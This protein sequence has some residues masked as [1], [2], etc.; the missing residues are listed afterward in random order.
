MTHIKDLL[1]ILIG[2]AVEKTL[3]ETA[4]PG[5]EDM[6]L[7]LKKQHGEDSPVPFKIAWAKYSANKKKKKGSTRNEVYVP[8]PR[9]P[10]ASVVAN[11]EVGGEKT[12]EQLKMEIIFAIQADKEL[13]KSVEE[14]MLSDASSPEDLKTYAEA[15][16]LL[17]KIIAEKEQMLVSLGKL[18]KT[19]PS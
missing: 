13:L 15:K 18:S 12:T 4:P 8:R 6:V 3:E 19:K 16:R 10:V 7:A 11:S 14:E 2:E 1:R 9:N 5:M 17:V